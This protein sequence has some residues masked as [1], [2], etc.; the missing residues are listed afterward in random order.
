MKYCWMV[1][2]NTIIQPYPKVIQY[3]GQAKIFR[4]ILETIRLWKIREKLNKKN[5][6]KWVWNFKYHILS[7]VV[8]LHIVCI[9]SVY[10]SAHGYLVTALLTMC[11]VSQFSKELCL[12]LMSLFVHFKACL[13]IK[14]KLISFKVL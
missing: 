4:F 12:V 9:I 10:Y 8:I 14:I 1:A 5:I 6:K 11:Q 3:N 2:S 7:Y 13:Q